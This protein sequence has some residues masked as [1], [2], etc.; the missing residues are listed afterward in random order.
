[1]KHD[2][3]AQEKNDRYLKRYRFIDYV[4]ENSRESLRLEHY[5]IQQVLYALEDELKRG[6]VKAVLEIITGLKQT[7]N[8][9]TKQQEVLDDGR[10]ETEQ[11]G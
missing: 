4:A 8:R 9:L 6:G 3:S 1:M 11:V 10:E 7:T 2:R 5:Y